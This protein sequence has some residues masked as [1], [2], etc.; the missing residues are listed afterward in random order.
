MKYAIELVSYSE[1]ARIESL[2][3][4]N[5]LYKEYKIKAKNYIRGLF[6]PKQFKSQYK[7][8]DIGRLLLVGDLLME[9]LK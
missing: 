7:N 5:A 3:G 6:I 1:Y 8:S 9:A 4:E 2:L